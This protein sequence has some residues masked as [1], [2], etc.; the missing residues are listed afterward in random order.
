MPKVET[1]MVQMRLIMNQEGTNKINLEFGKKFMEMI[2]EVSAETI[3]G[4]IRNAH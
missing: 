1:F 4:K 3:S 2:L